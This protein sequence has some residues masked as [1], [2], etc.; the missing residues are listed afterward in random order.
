MLDKKGNPYLLEVNAS[1]GTEGIEKVSKVDIVEHLIEFV[2]D[3]RNW[4][5]QPRECGIKE[6]IEVLGMG[7]MIAKFDTGNSVHSC[8]L[9]AQDITVKDNTVK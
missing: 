1:P 9:D 2:K 4:S 8:S 6:I 7:E 5:R 3:K